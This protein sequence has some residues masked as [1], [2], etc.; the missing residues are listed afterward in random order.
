MLTC[1]E[2]C[3]AHSRCSINHLKNIYST[4]SLFFKVYIIKG[5]EAVQNMLFQNGATVA[6]CL[7]WA[8]G[9]WESTDAERDLCPAFYLTKQVRRSLLRHVPSLYLEEK[10]ILIP[11]DYESMPKCVCTNKLR[12][13]I[14]RFHYFHHA[15]PSH[16]PTG[17][18]PQAQAAGHILTIYCSSFKK[19]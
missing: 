16:W 9:T 14:L 6:C 19:I 5:T 17:Y 2:Q 12:K 7:F 18:C 3:P 8:E 11:G 10:N 1:I 13:T 15:F 4:Y